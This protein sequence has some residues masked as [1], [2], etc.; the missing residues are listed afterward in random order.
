MPLSLL[1]N[2][3]T[4]EVQQCDWKVVS[5]WPNCILECLGIREVRHWKWKSVRRKNVF[6]HKHI[7]C[8]E[9]STV[10]PNSPGRGHGQIWNEALIRAE[11]GKG[12]VAVILLIGSGAVNPISCK[13]HQLWPPAERSQEQHTE[14]ELDLLHVQFT[15]HP[16]K[17]AKWYAGRDTGADVWMYWLLVT[18]NHEDQEWD[19]CLST[20]GRRFLP[21]N[22]D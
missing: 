6:F 9:D 11:A 19:Y 15:A 4:L 10:V 13:S 12:I 22:V 20:H 3:G 21:N 18:H 7:P 2:E 1:C 5:A 8:G 16:E 17:Q 14:W